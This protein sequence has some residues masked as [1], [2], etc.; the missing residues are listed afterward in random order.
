[1]C[2]YSTPFLRV[3]KGL[4]GRNVVK[5]WF[6]SFQAVII[7]TFD[8]KLLEDAATLLFGYNVNYVWN[9][10][11]HYNESYNDN[12]RVSRGSLHGL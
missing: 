5:C 10:H 12:Y 6:L 7:T 11:Y 8:A 1:M 3:H 2:Y 4:F 9:L